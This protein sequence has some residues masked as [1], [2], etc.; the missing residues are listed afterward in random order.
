MLS[1]R[2]SFRDGVQEESTRVCNP[3]PKCI[4][5]AVEGHSKFK[6][7][8]I[9]GDTHKEKTKRCTPFQVL[10]FYTVFGGSEEAVP[11]ISNL[12]SIPRLDS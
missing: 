10:G 3:C 11:A 1:F 8:S 12:P 5:P 7:S 2:K 6:G 9:S 4:Y